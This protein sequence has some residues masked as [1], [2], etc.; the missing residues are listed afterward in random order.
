MP[1]E[2]PPM[3]RKSALVEADEVEDVR[4]AGARRA[5]GSRLTEGRD[6]VGAWSSGRQSCSGM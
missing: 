4:R 3:G 6:D 1:V 2:N 5:A